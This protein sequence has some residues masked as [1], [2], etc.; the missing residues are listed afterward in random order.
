MIAPHFFKILLQGSDEFIVGIRLIWGANCPSVKGRD[1]SSLT[2]ESSGMNR[3]DFLF[4]IAMKG[5][6]QGLNIVPHFS[7]MS[8]C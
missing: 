4:H 1:R 5:F 7:N 3:L 8:Y 2:R 6:R